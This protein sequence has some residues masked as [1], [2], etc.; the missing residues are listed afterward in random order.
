VT[1]INRVSKSIKLIIVVLLLSGC[2]SLTYEHPE[3]GRVEYSRWWSQ[4]IGAVEIQ[5]D[6][7]PPVKLSLSKQKADM[8]EVDKIAE[9]VVKGM[10]F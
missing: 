6:G 10:R 3:Y 7:N 1:T 8:P 2:A 9:A 5:I 4:E